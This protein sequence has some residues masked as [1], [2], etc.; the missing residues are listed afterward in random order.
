ML[1]RSHGAN[2]TFV[3]WGALHGCYQVIGNIFR[4]YIYSPKY[5]T[6]ISKAFSTLF[7]FILVAFAWILF[8]ANNVNDAFQIIEKIFTQQGDLFVDESS[9]IYGFAGLFI[10]IIKDFKDNFNINIHLMHSKYVAIRYISVI[11]LITYI[12]L[13]GSFGSGQFIYFQF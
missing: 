6:F 4:K 11:A 1:F 7:C 9:F 10:L 5:T 2:W 12:I 8:R 13:F 3:L